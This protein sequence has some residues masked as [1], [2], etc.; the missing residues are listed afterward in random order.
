VSPKAAMKEKDDAAKAEVGGAPEA[1]P[2]G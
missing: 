1:A 2:Q